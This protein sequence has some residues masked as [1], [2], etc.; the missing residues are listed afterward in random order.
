MSSRLPDDPPTTEK[1]RRFLAK[2]P[3]LR[4]K[5]DP[6]PAWSDELIG[7]L[8]DMGVVD[9]LDLKGHYTGTVVDNPPDPA[10][11]RK[12]AETFPDAWLEDPALTD[13]TDPILEPYRDRITWDAPIHSID[14][15]EALPLEPRIAAAGF[16]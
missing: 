1:L 12:L 15:I 6:T 10:L 16:R 8:R 13:E 7:E 4:F 9:S 11:Y 3:T 5:L 2:Y 14:D